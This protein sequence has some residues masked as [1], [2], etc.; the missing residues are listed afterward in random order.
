MEKT[1]LLKVLEAAASECGCAVAE[2]DF[3]DDDNVFDVTLTK[4]DGAVNLGDC[5]YVHRAVL[6]AFDRDVEDYALTVGSA[7][8][9]GAE[10]DALLKDVDNE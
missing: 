8:I 3:N 4:E 7:G 10:A 9:S 2:L 1:E 6:A 5:E